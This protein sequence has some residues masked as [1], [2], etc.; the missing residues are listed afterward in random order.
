MA[1]Q[2]PQLPLIQVPMPQEQTQNHNLP[3]LQM[4]QSQ[5]Q[6]PDFVN[7]PNIDIN[8]KRQMLNQINQPQVVADVS[9]QSMAIAGANRQG[10][11]WAG[12]LGNLGSY[13]AAAGSAYGTGANPSQGLLNATNATR[14]LT[15]DIQQYDAMKPYYQQMGYDLSKLDPRRG[16]AGIATT[17]EKMVDLQSK[18]AERDYLNDYR[19]TLAQARAAQ[20]AQTAGTK[21]VTIGTLRMMSP[22]FKKMIDAQYGFGNGQNLKLLDQVVPASI[23]QGYMPAVT[24]TNNMVYSGGLNSSQNKTGRS[25]IYY[26][27]NGGSRSNKR[28]GVSLIIK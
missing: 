11:D 10:I 22:Q 17:P 21:G 15:Q 8:T 16:G 23:V 20:A 27:G 7:N 26:H 9:P 1:Q 19:Q 25:D 4:P 5:A 24:K 6:V 14:K 18:I 3:P 2:Y 13:V 12:L 28:P